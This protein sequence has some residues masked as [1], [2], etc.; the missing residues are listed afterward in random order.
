VRGAVALSNHSC[1]QRT[2]HAGGSSPPSACGADRKEIILVDDG[3]TDGTRELLAAMADQPDLRIFFHPENRG[4]GAALKTGFLA[5]S[6]AIVLVQDADLEYDPADFP[7][8]VAPILAN[9]A[10][11]VFGSRF[12]YRDA[13]RRQ[14]YW[15]G[16][17][18]RV[19]VE[20]LYRPSVDRHGNLL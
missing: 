17:G 20:L 3:S 9:Q 1:F 11:V 8:L 12:L 15:H 2:Q 5:A 16:L 10:D 14:S 4:K 13:R 7:A 6:G 19:L 18:N